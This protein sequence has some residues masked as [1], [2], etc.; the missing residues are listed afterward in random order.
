[1]PGKREDIKGKHHVLLA[2]ILAEGN[3]L[4]IAAVEILQFELR[5]LIANLK[6]GSRRLCV[7]G[8]QLIG[9][10]RCQHRCHQHP[11]GKNGQQNPSPHHRH[12]SQVSARLSWKAANGQRLDERLSAET[13]GPHFV[14]GG[15]ELC[16]MLAEIQTVRMS[17]VTLNDILLTVRDRGR[18]RV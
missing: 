8:E 15:G 16:T 1:T 4:E 3:V 6:L 11:T 5:S 2:A 9:K 7:V 12:A 14:D 18:S 10:G 17:L 13:S